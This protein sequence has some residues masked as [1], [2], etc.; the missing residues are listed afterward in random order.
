MTK[1]IEVTRED[2]LHERATILRELNTTLEDI[3]KRART[4]ALVGREWPAWDRLQSIAFLLS[5]DEC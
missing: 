1:T 5:D 2:L 3:T 4:Y